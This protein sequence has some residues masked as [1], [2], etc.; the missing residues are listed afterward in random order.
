[1]DSYSLS[2]KKINLGRWI[3][4]QQPK[5][6]KTK[7][8]TKET[9]LPLCNSQNKN[10]KK[11]NEPLDNSF[12]ASPEELVDYFENLYMDGAPQLSRL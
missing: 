5:K 3:Q 4:I 9:K 2:L 12:K 6:D 1:M 11:F 8:K 10:K 7:T